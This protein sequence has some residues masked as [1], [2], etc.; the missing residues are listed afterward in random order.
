M[1]RDWDTS[2]F[3][4]HGLGSS[5]GLGLESF[6]FVAIRPDFVVHFFLGL[7]AAREGIFARP[8]WQMPSYTLS[9]SSSKV[10]VR[11]CVYIRTSRHVRATRNEVVS[12]QRGDPGLEPNML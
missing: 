6:S 3:G 9:I 4:I 1:L 8:S 5:R 2:D 11:L 10:F 12:Q 7:K